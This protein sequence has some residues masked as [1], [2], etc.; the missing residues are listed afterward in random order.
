MI[1]ILGSTVSPALRD[2]AHRLRMVKDY[3]PSSKERPIADVKLNSILDLKYCRLDKVFSFGI[4]DTCYKVE[5]V[6]MWYPYRKIPCWGVYVRHKGWIN[7]LTELEGLRP[8]E[9]A[10]WG[11]DVLTAFLPDNGGMPTVGEDDVAAVPIPRIDPRQDSPLR[12]GIQ[13]LTSKLM[14]LSKIITT[15]GGVPVFN[16]DMPA[17][18]PENPFPALQPENRLPALQPEN[19]IPALQPE[20]LIDID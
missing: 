2:F 14:Q 10:S 3:N 11:D 16:P 18:Q 5:L 17:L 8:G 4:K 6:S 1:P 20:N 7:H 12:E 13:L 9:C 15:G 19:R